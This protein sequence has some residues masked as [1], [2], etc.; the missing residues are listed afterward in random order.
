LHAE[1]IRQS[2]GG[3]VV[4]DDVSVELRHG[5]VVLL[6]GSNGS[7][8][9]T[10][11]NILTGSLAP[12]AG[13]IEVSSPT[14]QDRFAFPRRWWRTFNFADH[15]TPERVARAGISRTWQEIRLFASQ[16]LRDNV[17]LATQKMRG[18]N[19][20]S[21][22]LSPG[23]VRRETETANA[24]A[25][26]LLERFGLGHRSQSQADQVSLGQSK[27]VAI[28]RSIQAGGRIIFLDE[29]L[30]GLDANGIHDVI[31][32]LAELVRGGDVTLVI[33]EH[34]F[35]IPL[36]IGLASVVWTLSQGRLTV[37]SPQ[38]AYN[39]SPKADAGDLTR[40]ITAV[41]G[42]GST[43]R[44]TELPGGA[45]LSVAERQASS[46]KPPVFELRDVV[47]CRGRTPIIGKMREDG[48]F[49]GLSLT[50]PEGSLAVLHAP[51]GWGKTTLLEALAGLIPIHQGTIAVD[52][53]A[54]ER[55]ATWTRTQRG[56]AI[57]Q[58]RYHSF[59]NLSVV[60]T[61]RLAGAQD[62]AKDFDAFLKR[63]LGDLS[64]GQKQ[65]IALAVALARADARV[66]A[67]D[68]PFSMLDAATIDRIRSDIARQ[69]SGATLILVPAAHES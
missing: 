22:L 6:R 64:G 44:H 65:Q 62:R 5:E 41:A 52:G 43:I 33:V 47:V 45:I 49:E 4:I 55:D 57:L 58:S 9:T 26:A 68:E 10:L 16:S 17:A 25:H 13:T 37:E 7:G 59:D 19:P 53:T 14:A 12:D 56:L 66:R 31:A 69:T 36:I 67:L 3:T 20:L 50:L 2:F 24:R 23:A 15:F 48:S 28:A 35:N 42:P 29:P 18:E 38:R 32:F 1:N 63:R 54:I 61:L 40:W 46:D 11:L 30:A 21:V 34:V 51:N 27:R 60:E 8:K 39:D